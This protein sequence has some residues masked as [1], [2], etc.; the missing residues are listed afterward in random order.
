MPVKVA[1]KAIFEALLPCL[2]PELVVIIV[3]E[4]DG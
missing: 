2:A 4:K 3:F 1:A